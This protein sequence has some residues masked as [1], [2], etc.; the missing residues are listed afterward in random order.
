MRTILIL[1]FVVYLA[2]LTGLVLFKGPLFYRVVPATEEYKNKTEK[3]SY[4]RYNLKP[5]KTINAFMDPHPSTSFASRFYN[6]AGNIAL[7]IPFGF[8][9]PLVFRNR[10]SFDTVIGAT[11]LLSL[12]FEVFQFITG[13]GQL[14]VDDLILNT[15]GGI[16]GYILFALFN[17]LTSG[18]YVRRQ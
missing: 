11:F 17:S 3:A 15:L 10:R 7:F 1:V 5:F 14:D 12:F 4:R 6:L 18:K 9:F 8:L 2:A 13:I 16:V